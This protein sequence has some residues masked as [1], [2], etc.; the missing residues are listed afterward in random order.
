MSG[1]YGKVTKERSCL[2]CKAMFMA[3]QKNSMTWQ[4]YCPK[5]VKAHV[6][7]GKSYNI[8][9]EGVVIYGKA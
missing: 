7:M 9:D 1:H 5:C 8:S 4:D 3:K 6:W 2:Y